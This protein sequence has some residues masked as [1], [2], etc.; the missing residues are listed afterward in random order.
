V[1][2]A[3]VV[4][5]YILHIAEVQDGR[6]VLQP[7]VLWLHGKPERTHATAAELSP[8]IEPALKAVGWNKGSAGELLRTIRDQSGLLTG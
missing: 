2:Q 1:T 7:A 5:E 6:R 4:S 3:R 8:H